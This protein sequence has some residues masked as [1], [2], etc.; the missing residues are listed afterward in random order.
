MAQSTHLAK[1]SMLTLSILMALHA[2][3]DDTA[4][5]QEADL[6]TQKIIINKTL[7][8]KVGEST[9]TAEQLSEQNAQDAH[10]L[11]RYHT[12]VDVAEVGRYGNKG[13]AIRGVDGNRV[14][15]NIDGVGLPEVE[16]NEIFSPYGYMY[17]G[18][19][20]P[21][22]DMMRGV[23]IATGADSV[24]TGSGAVGG[25]ISYQTK[26]P[27][28]LINHHE[29]FGGYVKTGYAS[30]NSEKSISTGLAFANEQVEALLNY[31]HK[32]GN[33][34]KNHA[35]RRFDGDQL[36]VGYTFSAEDMPGRLKSLLYPNP[37][38]FNRDALLGKFYYHINEHHRL[39][40]HGLYQRQRTHMNTDINASFGS[41]TSVD[42][43]RAKDKEE[44]ESYGINYR[45]QPDNAWLHEATLGYTRSDVT[46]LAD[47]WIY[48]RSWSGDEVTFDYREYR[49]TKTETNQYQLNLQSSPFELGRAGEH[50]LSLT[51]SAIKA[52]RTTSAS[53][54]KEDGSLNYLNHPFVDVKKNSHHIAISDQISFGNRL[55]ALLGIRYD[56][57]KYTPYFQNDVFG[58]DENTR[59]HQTC[60]TN[61]ALG[62]FCDAY[63]AGDH[64]NKTKFSHTSWSGML[65]YQLIPEKLTTRYKIG[66]GFLA[67]TGTQIYRNFQGLGVLEVPNYALKPET[68]LNQELE[69]EFKPAANTSLTASGYLS[70][71]KNFIHTKFW[72][73]ET[74]GCN[75]RATCL[76]STNLDKAKV[77]GFKLGIKSDISDKLNLDG[78][79]NLTA[80]YHI[81]K[82]SATVE[83]DH[84]GTFKINTLAATP[85]SF[86]LGADYVSPNQDWQLHTRVRGLM[87]KKAKDTK[88]LEVAPTYDIKT[89]NCPYVGY[90]Y[91]CSYDGYTQDESGAWTKTE[92][93][94]T[95]Y[96]EYVDTY[97]H[98]NRSKNAILVDVYG[99]R[100][101]GK[102]KQLTLN[103]GVYNLTNVKYIPWE[104][105]RM[106]S[107]ANV[108]NMVDADGYG[109]ARYTAPGRN[110]ALSLTYE[111]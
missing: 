30:K 34:T 97:K 12:E 105:L 99:S 35:M 13:F 62:G 64:L 18:R 44:L 50:R 100:K 78:K 43:R 88:T 5:V 76:Q 108:N 47:T 9:L 89:V 14:A 106:F 90:E 51:A 67:P 85:S 26:E 3:A 49:P 6:G 101:F 82:D 21:D 95:G 84:D 4:S 102:D 77:Y 96:A 17:E 103:A 54:L 41:R 37:M 56:N 91:Y 65:N 59:I 70:N 61:N 53:V 60:V 72:E 74:G 109:F 104:S 55:Q 46:G 27:R 73:G 2:H 52:D 94:R 58:A 19:F 22:L 79:L 31:T 71:Y 16:I 25:S 29:N 92:R 10:D 86:I 40:L 81:A 24:L 66:T 63:R 75:G 38:S 11:V 80:D 69:F 83:S 1:Y 28:D 7:N 48:D 33:E 39:G 20:N 110:Y 98:A 45:Y 32:E 107:N 93:T 111:F 68:S 23:R 42:P 36:S 57:F 15:M 87:R 8:K